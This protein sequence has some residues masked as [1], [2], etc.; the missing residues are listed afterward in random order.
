M[1]IEEKRFEKMLSR[2][3]SGAG[4][5]KKGSGFSK[6]I[7]TLVIILNVVFTVSVL[8]IFKDT[9]TEPASLIVAWF[10]FTTGELW[11]LASVKKAKVK[12]EKNEFGDNR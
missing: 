8:W 11:L 12:E 9:G 6:F 1:D 10:A 3:M 4:R 7:I 5:K 2:S